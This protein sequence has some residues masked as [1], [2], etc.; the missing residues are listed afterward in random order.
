MSEVLQIIFIALSVVDFLCI[1]APLEKLNTLIEDILEAEDSLAADI[2]LADL[3]KEYFSP[4]TV[5]CNHPHLQPN[6]VRKLTKYISQLA[7]PSK[8][9]RRAMREGVANSSSGS[10]TRDTLGDIGTPILSRL[11]KILERSIKAGEDLDPLRT[12]THLP[13]VPSSPSKSKKG[14]KVPVDGIDV[15]EDGPTV[16]DS[17]SQQLTESDVHELAARLEVSRDSILAAECCMALL[18]GESLTKQVRDLLSMTLF[19]LLS[20]TAALLRGVNHNLP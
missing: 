10:K 20:R 2:E 14:Q 16:H 18:S 11:M 3:P 12:S 7:R 15:Q 6:I 1:T 8:R 5:D 17:H 9:S 19:G 4:L 13:P